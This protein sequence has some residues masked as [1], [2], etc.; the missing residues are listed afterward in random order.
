MRRSRCDP[1]AIHFPPPPFLPCPTD[2]FSCPTR[3]AFPPWARHRHVCLV[4]WELQSASLSGHTQMR[5]HP[6]SYTLADS[7]TYDTP[8]HGGPSTQLCRSI[9]V[10]VRQKSRTCLVPLVLIS[11]SSPAGLYSC[12]NT[13]QSGVTL[14]ILKFP[15]SL[16]HLQGISIRVLRPFVLKVVVSYLSRTDFSSQYVL[17][18][19]FHNSQLLTIAFSLTEGGADP[20]YDSKLGYDP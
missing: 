7:G 4:A 1:R 5:P 20:S 14:D 3:F 2:L 8:E 16:P 10:H 17:S 9:H 15:F 18:T 12:P 6:S 19:S 13:L 11:T